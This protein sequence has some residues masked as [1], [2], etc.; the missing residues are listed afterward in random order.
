MSDRDYG[1][2]EIFSIQMWVPSNKPEIPSASA[3]PF[4]LTGIESAGLSS[5][6]IRQPEPVKR[7]GV[8]E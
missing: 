5:P 4:Y 3:L 8:R 7:E 1:L 2:V 6:V